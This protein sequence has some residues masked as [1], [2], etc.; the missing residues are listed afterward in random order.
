[1]VGVKSERNINATKIVQKMTKNLKDNTNDS[2]TSNEDDKIYQAEYA[3]K[4]EKFMKTCLSKEQYELFEETKMVRDEIE[5]D[6]GIE[7]SSEVYINRL[8]IYKNNIDN[9]E[10]YLNNYKEI[11]MKK[12][13]IKRLQVR[14]KTSKFNQEKDNK[15]GN[16]NFYLKNNKNSVNIYEYQEVIQLET[17]DMFGDTALGSATSKRTA[18]IIS[19]T[20]CHFGCLNKDI[21][22]YIKFSNDKK[23]KNNINYNKK[24]KI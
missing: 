8:K 7:L 16:E 2:N 14:S 9:N 19:A 6:N 13:R 15:E 4:I 18:T 22:N 17:G 3:Q 20:E 12:A 23:R 1:M 21:Y 11:V 5:R 10:N 24:W